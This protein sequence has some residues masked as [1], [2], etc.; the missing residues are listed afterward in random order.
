MLLARPG[1]LT[2]LCLIALLGCK[3][4]TFGTEDPVI[5]PAQLAVVAGARIAG[6]NVTI[7][8]PWMAHATDSLAIGI[9][10][11]PASW[12]A[13]DPEHPEG[14]RLPL[15]DTLRGGAHEIVL[16]PPGGA[17][18]PIG[19]ITTGGFTELR[20]LDQQFYGPSQ[21]VPYLPGLVGLAGLAGPCGIQLA[22]LDARNA[23][24]RTFANG[25]TCA[26]F[27][28]GSSFDPSRFLMTEA[29]SD[30]LWHRAAVTRGGLE[31]D[32]TTLT[33]VSQGV[34]HEIGPGI[35]LDA[36]KAW[37]NIWGPS[38][39]APISMVDGGNYRLS[40]HVA[41]SPDGRWAVPDHHVSDSG[42]LVI[43]RT[44]GSHHWARGWGQHVRTL[45]A[46]DGRLVVI[47]QDQGFIGHA[48]A[49]TGEALDSVPLDAP[50]F[51][52]TSVAT[53]VGPG[54]IVIPYYV[55]GHWVMSVRDPGTLL[56]IAHP[57]SPALS[58]CPFYAD[59]Q[60]VDDPS[61]RRFYIVD[62]VGC[63]PAPIATFQ[64]P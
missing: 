26:Y 58:N 15:P 31:I 56:E 45:F 7:T 55:D 32:T 64:L 9:D 53:L 41:F 19:V 38:V 3:A 16:Y 61:L 24:V 25:M 42:V 6:G 60:A 11:L 54:W 28:I 48:D 27:G 57:V 18:T 52:E 30:H 37:T 13:R 33:A 39:P 46:P 2:T 59:G 35:Y 40:E 63:S 1:S 5:D 12:V 43:D 62:V 8:A 4:E 50:R 47:G 44:D 17:R 20:Y 22:I 14:F 23:T 34:T 51:T 49:A 29:G 36:S 10:D 21:P